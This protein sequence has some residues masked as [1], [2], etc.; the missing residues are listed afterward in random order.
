MKNFLIT[1]AAIGFSMN[2]MAQ[3]SDSVTVKDYE[4]A[5][6]FLS[7]NISKYIDHPRVEPHWLSDDKFWYRDLNSKGSEFILVNASNGKKSSAFDQQ[8]LATA[9]SVATDKSYKAEMLPFSDFFFSEDLQ[10]IFF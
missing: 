7:P 5:E 1:L 2:T 6:A 4:H 10:F 8:K 9:L 3:Q